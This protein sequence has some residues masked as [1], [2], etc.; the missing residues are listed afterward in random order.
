MKINRQPAIRVTAS[1]KPRDCVQTGNEGRRMLR[2]PRR[3]CRE[4]P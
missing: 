3:R 1:N 2:R 4:S